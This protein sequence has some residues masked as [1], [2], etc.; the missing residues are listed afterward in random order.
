MRKE[1]NNFYLSFG[2]HTTVI[3][4]AKRANISVINRAVVDG[5]N[6]DIKCQVKA[7]ITKGGSIA[8]R[9]I[10]QTGSITITCADIDQQIY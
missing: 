2:N 10:S 6:G 7:W 9:C 4:I 8:Y 3:A 1:D 5:L